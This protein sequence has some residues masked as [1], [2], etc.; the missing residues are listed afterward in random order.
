MLRGRHGLA[1]WSR[2]RARLERVAERQ[3]GR[4]RVQRVPRGERKRP[5]AVASAAAAARTI[6]GPVMQRARC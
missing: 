6:V 5:V 4:A 2:L 1:F 3:A